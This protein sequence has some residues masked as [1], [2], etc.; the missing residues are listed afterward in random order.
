METVLQYDP[1]IGCLA[2]SRDQLLCWKETGK[3]SC[4]DGPF[5]DAYSNYCID[6]MQIQ[7][8]IPHRPSATVAQR[9]PGHTQYSLDGEIR[10]NLIIHGALFLHPGEHLWHQLLGLFTWQWSDS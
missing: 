7:F 6:S 8:P 10:V 3:S 9:R 2:V 1:I 5:N 4:R